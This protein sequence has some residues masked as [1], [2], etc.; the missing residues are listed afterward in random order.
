VTTLASTAAAEEAIIIHPSTIGQIE[1]VPGVWRPSRGGVKRKLITKIVK[2]VLE[3]GGVGD[4]VMEGL[5]G[6]DVS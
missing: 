3:K 6:V 4:E 1:D 5:D 2:I